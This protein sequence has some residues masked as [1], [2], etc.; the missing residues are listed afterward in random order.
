MAAGILIN[1]AWSPAVD[2]DGN[3]I[4]DARAYYY[5]DE[6][7]TLATIYADENLSIPLPNPLEANSSGRWPIVWADDADTYTVT[8]VA[9]YGPAGVPFTVTGL[10]ASQATDILVMQASAAAA[11]EAEAAAAASVGA[12]EDILALVGTLPDINPIVIAGLAKVDGSN[13]V[14]DSA[15]DFT[16]AIRSQQSGSGALEESVQATLRRVVYSDQYSTPQQAIAAAGNNGQVIF[17]PGGT[18]VLT[19]PL[20]LTGLNN[21]TLTG[22]GHTMR[23]GASRINAYFDLSGSNNCIVEGF[24]FDGRQS[25][26][27]VYTQADFAAN[28]LTYNTPVIADGVVASWSNVTVRNCT[29]TG[30]YTNAVW[31]K[32]GAGI[33]V[34]NNVFNA[35]VCNQTLTGTPAAQQ[36]IFVMLQTCGGQMKVQGNQF[37]GAATTNPALPPC[38]VFFSGV[39]G[40]LVISDNF[41][42]YCGRDNTG[43]H[44]LGVFDGYGDVQN[45][46]VLD[47]VCTNVMGQFMR[48]A[49]TRTA[50]VRGN[51]FIKSANAENGYSGLTIEGVVSF[52]GA[53]GTGCTDIVISGNAFE[54]TSSRDAYTVGVNSFDWGSIN[55]R[56]RVEDNSFTTCLRPVRTE[57]PYDDLY[58]GLNKINGQSTIEVQ[59]PSPGITSTAGTQANSRFDNL[60]ICENTIINRTSASGALA[61][62]IRLNDAATTALVGNFRV[63]NNNIQGLL[64]SAQGIVILT[65]STTPANTR[66]IV[67]GNFIQGYNYN[68]YI[69]EDGYTLLENNVSLLPGTSHILNQSTTTLVRR[70]NSFGTGILSGTGTLASGVATITSDQITTDANNPTRIV[71][72]RK[73]GGTANG[74]LTVT[75]ANGSATVTSKD[76]ANATVT[77]DNGT[78]EHEIQ[79]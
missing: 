38:G 24:N 25:V 6:T 20:L 43:T 75:Y 65:Q 33:T 23:C 49:D 29:L 1:P 53:A 48:L 11:D 68:F 31:F 66:R 2:S 60:R 45:A 50:Q 52:R 61:I 67:R 64:N 27:P 74:F 78:F 14:G 62:N 42:D 41:A 17:R 32:A 8:T 5:V 16:S 71:L 47:N 58:I 70:G 4:P 77:T 79:N 22:F 37:L 34:E 7:T 10:Q 44:R 30:M 26:M 12:Y 28:Q 18:T 3:P 59:F 69:R 54:D 36:W 39:Q 15:V 21:V 13:V 19:T 76:A 9:P 46:Y 57:G 72:S 40:Q 51:K 73:G 35:P 63:E 55:K 56:I